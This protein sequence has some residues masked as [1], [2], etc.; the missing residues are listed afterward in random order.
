MPFS[1]EALSY[2]AAF[3]AGHGSR[4]RQLCTTLLQRAAAA[5]LTLAAVGRMMSRGIRGGVVV[6]S[7]L[8]AAAAAA[9]AALQARD[10]PMFQFDDASDWAAPPPPTPGD[11]EVVSPEE[12]QRYMACFRG[13]VDDAIAAEGG[14]RSARRALAQRHITVVW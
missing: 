11:F 2:I 6:P 4:V 10:E 8:E 5:G 1:H 3:D 13:T 14:D 9:A 7:A 12:W